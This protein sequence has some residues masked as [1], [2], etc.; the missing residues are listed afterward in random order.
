MLTYL[1]IGIALLTYC[2]ISRAMREF[3]DFKKDILEY[4]I[5]WLISTLLCI[6][7]WPV[8]VVWAVYDAIKMVQEEEL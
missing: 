2:H 6:M 7:L 8:I 3:E 4:P 5:C 1:I